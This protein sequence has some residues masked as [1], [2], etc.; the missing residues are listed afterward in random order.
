MTTRRLFSSF[1]RGT[2]YGQFARVF[3]YN[4]FIFATWIPAVIFFH[5]NIGEVTRISGPSMYPYL[6]TSYNENQKEDRCWV[7]KFRPTQNLQRGMLVSFRSPYH[8]EVLAIKRVIAVEGDR[9]ITHAPYPL[10]IADVPAGH[11]WVEG[12]N[13]DANKTLDSNHYGPIPLNLIQGRVTHVLW[14]W[15]SF[16]AV[17]WWEFKGRTRVLKGRKESALRF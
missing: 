9:V 7:N 1:N 2:Q 17:R 6:N 10:P 11:V 13:R 15:T 5:D 16:G 3:G 14:P 12:D 4:L 8:P